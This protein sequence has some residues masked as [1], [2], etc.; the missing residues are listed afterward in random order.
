MR[1]GHQLRPDMHANGEPCTFKGWLLTGLLWEPQCAR[2]ARG[3]SLNNG[4]HTRRCYPDVRFEFQAGIGCL[5]SSCL[6]AAHK[7]LLSRF[8]LTNQP[9]RLHADSELHACPL[10]ERTMQLQERRDGGQKM[11]QGGEHQK[12]CMIGCTIVAYRV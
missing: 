5:T 12:G 8:L 1:G 7:V 11:G 10:A 6:L 3:D 2:E 4:E 9:A